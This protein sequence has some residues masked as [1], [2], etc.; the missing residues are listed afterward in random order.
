MPMIQTELRIQVEGVQTPLLVKRSSLQVNSCEQITL[1]VEGVKPQAQNP[2]PAKLVGNKP[3]K[4][5][6]PQKRVVVATYHPPLSNAK[7][8]AIYDGGQ[9]SGLKVKVGGSKLAPLTQPL[10]YMDRT[11]SA[12]GARPTI[13]LENES[14][15]PRTAV[16]LVGSDLP[17]DAKKVEQVTRLLSV[18]RG[19]TK[20]LAKQPMRKK[21]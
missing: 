11:A 14:A 18:A 7:F 10:V 1:L 2:Q 8:V 16:L 19:S 12:L 3:A 5:A 15:V 21:A 9:G 17:K 13:V 4:A 20:R 6:K